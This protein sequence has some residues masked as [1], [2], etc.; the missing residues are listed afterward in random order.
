[1]IYSKNKKK[2]LVLLVFVFLL[3]ASANIHSLSK[4]NVETAESVPRVVLLELFIQSDCNICPE[5]EFC[6]EDLFWE[7]GPEKIILLEEHLWSDGYDTRETNDR[8]DWYV[9]EGTKGT[10][11]LF[12]NGSVKRVQGLLCE[13]LEDNY[14]CCKKI[15]DSELNNFSYIKISAQKTPEDDGLAVEGKVNNVSSVIL[16][17]LAVCGMVYQDG[18]DP[19]LYYWVRDIFM[20]QDLPKQF[21]PE[22]SIGYRFVSELL[23]PEEDRD[24]FHAVIFIQNLKTKEVLQA[25]YVE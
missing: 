7:Y 2:V 15:I 4:N 1:M 13:N 10:P 17:D 11:D 6:L 19:G 16:Q 9:T 12:I 5:V 3:L 24:K 23:I 22:D 20:F 8:Y 21:L 25:V 14:Y 18:D